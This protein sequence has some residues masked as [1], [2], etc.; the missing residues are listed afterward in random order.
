[1]INFLIRVIG[2]SMHKKNFWARLEDMTRYY[3]GL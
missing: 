3:P 2:V 1:M